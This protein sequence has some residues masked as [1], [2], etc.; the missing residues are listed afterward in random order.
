M[1]IPENAKR[2]FKGVIFDVYQWDQKM[3]DGSTE[4]FEMIKRPDTIQILAT[5]GDKIV[6]TEQEQPAKPP[7]SA[8]LGGR[9]EEGE[10]PLKTAKRELLEEAG[11]ESDDW[12]LYKTYEPYSK[13]DWTI[14]LFIA[15]NCKKV[16]E[17]HLDPGERIKLVELNFE[18]FLDKIENEHF[19]GQE[20]A[21]DIYRMKHDTEKLEEF[22]KKLFGT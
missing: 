5:K 17:Q 11:L 20:I 12:E 1:K 6:L 19:W 9:G 13:F 15:R 10:E 2:V 7:F 4:T 21:N 3:F 22:R 8:F 18:E 16:A 14:C